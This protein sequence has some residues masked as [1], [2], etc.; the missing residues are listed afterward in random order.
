V[1][2]LLEIIRSQRHQFIIYHLMHDI[3]LA[4]ADTDILEKNV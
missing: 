3:L 4:D 2:K 1:Q